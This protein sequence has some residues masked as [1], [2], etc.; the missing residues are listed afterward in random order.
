VA[1]SKAGHEAVAKLLVASN[2]DVNKEGKYSQTALVAASKG[3]HAAVVKL[4]I[5][6]GAKAEDIHI[7]PMSPD[8]TDL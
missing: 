1:A 7:P 5:N 8:M 6:N 3:S 2:T 4:L